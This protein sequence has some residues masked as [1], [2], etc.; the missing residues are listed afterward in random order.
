M[1]LRIANLLKLGR[2]ET[3]HALLLGGILFFMTGSYTLIK[4]AR[5]ALFLARLPATLL[6]YV[7]LG[8]GVLTTVAAGAYARAT[9]QRPTWRSLED[10]TLAAAISLGLFAYLYGLHAR[11]VP[12]VFYLWVNAY[13]LIQLSQ[14]WSFANSVSNPREAKRIFGTIGTGGILGGLFGGALAAPLVTSLGLRSLLVIGGVLAGLVA[15]MVRLAVERG[16]LPPPERAREDPEGPVHPLSQPYVR[17]LALAAMC[18]VLVTTLL[19]YQFKAEIQRRDPSPHGLASFLGWFYTATNLAALIMQL[20]FTRWSLH[21]LGAG[22]S[23]A[24]LPAGLGIGAA[25]T[26]I[27]PGFGAVI[28]TRLWDQVMRLSINRTAGELFFFPLRPEIRRRAKALIEAGLERVGDGLAGLLILAAGLAMGASTWTIAAMVASLVVVWVMAWFRV[29][30]LYVSELGE[31]V[32][33]MNLDPHRAQVSLREASIL[34]EFSRLLESPY[35]R[36]VLHGLEMI[37][38]SAPERIDERIVPLMSHPSPRVR[39]RALSLAGARQMRQASAG[40][41]ALIGDPDPEVRIEAMRARVALGGADPI[42]ALEEFLDSS[43]LNLRRGAVSAIAEFAPPADEGRVRAILER[44]LRG[45]SEPERLIVAESLGRRPSGSLH[46][47]IPPLLSD[48]SLEVRNAALLSAGLTNR[49][50]LIPAMVGGLAIRESQAT[51]RRALAAFGNRVVGTLGDY[52]SDPAVAI[53]IRREIPRVLGQIGTAEAVGALFRCRDREDVRLA[54]RILKAENRIRERDPRI[55][56]P[57]RL[58]DED[59]DF[60][61][62]SYL[63]AFVHY[64]FCPIGG[65]RSAERLLCVALNERM[66]QALSRVFRRL[67]LLYPPQEI[68]AAYRGVLSE[69]PRGRGNSLEYLENALSPEHGRL[70]LPLV[71]DSGDEERLRFA[72]LRYGLRYRG[73]SESLA[74]ILQGQDAWLRTC[75][76]YVVGARRDHT[77][78]PLV[79]R[80]LG[81]R[82]AGVRETAAWAFA[83]L[84]AG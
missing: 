22:W 26:L 44:L 27:V 55:R 42:G 28:T 43:D 34:E 72:Q 24:V 45:G 3:R 61:A 7:F 17:W 83:A 6:P 20:F 35:E 46:D 63:F 62:G 36:L 8:V 30:R 21:A 16:A 75:A 80:S 15:P 82:D 33:R 14:F 13:G 59:L 1:L 64:R 32:R 19:D 74:E 76:L 68:F 25:A 41:E 78:Q 77:L 54:Y 71:D 66:D 49:R 10:V 18:S 51:A 38:E 31:N 73:P 60:D 23:A 58:V 5:D 79:E 84:A 37:E 53:E 50:E 39:A 12:I 65:P 57:A 70:V 29:R 56:F 69:S 52:L 47:L 11:W 4:T 9:Q 2:D 40:V 81:A 48:P 67:A